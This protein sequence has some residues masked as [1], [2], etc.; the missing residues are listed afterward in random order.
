MEIPWVRVLVR[1]DVYM[2]TC[3]ACNGVMTSH[4]AAD[5]DVFAATHT[6]HHAP[7]GYFGLGDAVAAIA[8]P[9]ARAFGKAP[10]TPCE[11]RQRAL[12]EMRVRRPW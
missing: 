11:A 2:A 12:N 6:T 3:E 8:K 7:A 5:V 9:I 4:E 1:P 10:C